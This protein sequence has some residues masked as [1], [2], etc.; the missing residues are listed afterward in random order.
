MSFKILE[1]IDK[2]D[3]NEI[4]RDQIA[5]ILEIE[6]EKQKDLALIDGQDQYLYDFDVYVEKSRP[7]EL[8][9]DTTGEE[10]SQP[11]IVNVLFDNDVF[12]NKGSD[13]VGNQKVLG[14]FYI[15]CYGSKNSYED[16]NGDMVDGDSESSKEADRVARL[17]RNILMAGE[18][19]YLGLRKTVLKRYVNR[20]EK[21]MPSDREGKYFETIVATRITLNVE[22]VESSPQKSGEDLEL[23]IHECEVG[24]SGLVSFDLSF[25][26]T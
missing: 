12:D 13:S 3:T 22:Y 2:Q 1:L 23:L 4:V 7:W 5:A 11:P 19:T 16:D 26:L 6:K 15:D 25:D 20:R 21:F 9:S 14:T 24:E 18:Y 8:L 10:L 17:V